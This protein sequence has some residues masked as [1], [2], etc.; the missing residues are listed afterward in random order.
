VEVKKSGGDGDGKPGA[1]I[2]RIIGPVETEMR[3]KIEAANRRLLVSGGAEPT[4][5]DL[6]GVFFQVLARGVDRAVFQA[7]KAAG[8]PI[9]IVEKPDK[10]EGL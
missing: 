5:A 7:A 4:L 3:Q 1:P 8:T 6:M 9:D 2:G 10:K